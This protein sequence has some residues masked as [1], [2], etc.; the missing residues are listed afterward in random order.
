MGKRPALA[1]LVKKWQQRLRLQDWDIEAVYVGP[2][3]D[4]FGNRFGDIHP[5]LQRRYA[6]MRVLDPR[7]REHPDIE[8]TIVHEQLHLHLF[9]FTCAFDSG[10]P[11]A[12]AEE[13]AIHA[14]ARALIEGYGKA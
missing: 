1:P 13:Q 6:K 4:G 12:L 3:H 7:K 9:P 11:E 8:N 14:I 10:S 2:D 5:D